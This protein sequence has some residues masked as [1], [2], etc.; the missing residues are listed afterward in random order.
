MRGPGGCAHSPPPATP[1]C[2][3]NNLQV[4]G[5]PLVRVPIA[6]V[7]LPPHTS[8][9][10][11]KTCRRHDDPGWRNG[12]SPHRHQAMS[13]TPADMLDDLQ[14]HRRNRKAASRG[15]E[16]KRCGTHCP[17]AK[18]CWP[19]TS[20]LQS[21]KTDRVADRVSPGSRVP[22]HQASGRFR[23]R[24]A[25]MWPRAH[26]PAGSHHEIR[27]GCTLANIQ[28]AEPLD[29]DQCHCAPSWR[30]CAGRQPAHFLS[31]SATRQRISPP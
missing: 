23:L 12:R 5:Q 14:A 24:S 27:Q 22:R 1:P 4:S 20:A 9:R 19:A 26:L 2:P 31:L 15:Y 8:P 30:R 11:H 3:S 6:A 21:P 10:Q 25:T 29:P 7:S 18:A 13:D 16:P 28:H 17:I